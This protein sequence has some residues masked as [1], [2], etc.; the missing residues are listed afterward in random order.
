MEQVQFA[1][2]GHTVYPGEAIYSRTIV[3]NALGNERV[4]L[5]YICICCRA[6]FDEDCLA[7]DE[8]IID[9]LEAA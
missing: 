1:S 8:E 6:R 5:E 7:S 2:C 4:Y 3:R 9:W